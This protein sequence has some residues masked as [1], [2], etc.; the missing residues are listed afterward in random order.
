LNGVQVPIA[1]KWN[2][3][4]WKAAVTPVAPSPTGATS[5]VLV[6]VSA[7]SPSDIWA[8]GTD[9]DS[10]TFTGLFEHVDGTAWSPVEGPRN[11]GAQLLTGVSALSPSDAQVAGGVLG[12][13]VVNESWNGARGAVQEPLDVIEG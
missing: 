6:A 1:E 10:S 12:D 2:G 4:T 5:V 7:S 8:V 3:K 13:Q 9:G 11:G